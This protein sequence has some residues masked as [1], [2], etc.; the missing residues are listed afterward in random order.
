MGKVFRNNT[1]RLTVLLVALILLFGGAA[2][3][4]NREVQL[5]DRAY[6]FY[7]SYQPEKA[8]QQFRA[9]I[10]EFPESSAKDA[11]LFWLAKSLLQVHALDEGVKMFAELRGR[12]PESPFI[13]YVRQEIGAIEDAAGIRKCADDTADG[14]KA[15]PGGTKNTLS[16]SRKGISEG[17]WREQYIVN[18]ASVLD[19]LGIFDVPWRGNNI[20]EDIENERM[21]FDEAKSMDVAPDAIRL[22][23]LIA[24]HHFNEDQADYLKRYLMICRFLTLAMNH[25]REEKLV[26]SLTVAYAMFP[27]TGERATAVSLLASELQKCARSGLALGDIHALYPDGTEYRRIKLSHLE[28]SI[29]QTIGALA[30][31]ETCIFWKEEGF[32]MIR[33]V[34]QDLECDPVYYRQSVSK[35]TVRMFIEELKEKRKAI[36]YNGAF[37]EPG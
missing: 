37:R 19:S 27:D 12:F 3:G 20:L 31:G 4:S 10:D 24:M 5:F 11:A 9:F 32:M 28:D 2:E 8:I 21:L 35:I 13:R 33:I 36:K 1:S 14:G 25:S 16:F 23:A 15:N 17:D 7:L 22:S 18:S 26:E 6:Y 34:P 30:D 29:R